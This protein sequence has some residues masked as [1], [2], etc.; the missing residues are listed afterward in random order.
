MEIVLKCWNNIC[1]CIVLRVF[2]VE[3]NSHTVTFKW[4]LKIGQ[5]LM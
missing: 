4:I 2:K 3:Y 1:V 5:W